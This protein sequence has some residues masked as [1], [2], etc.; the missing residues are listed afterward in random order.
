MAT[1]GRFSH[2]ARDVPK[3]TKHDGQLFASNLGGNRGP[4]TP[5]MFISSWVGTAVTV[6]C[7]PVPMVG[8]LSRGDRITS[9]NER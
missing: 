7:I 6:A 4:R 2:L 9:K 1:W 5:G 3:P 8:H